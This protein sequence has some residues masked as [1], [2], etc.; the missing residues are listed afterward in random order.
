[1]LRIVVS[2]FSD[3]RSYVA[4]TSP[5]GVV[6][7]AQEQVPFVFVRHCDSVPVFCRSP[8]NPA[9]AAKSTKSPMIK[10]PSGRFLRSGHVAAAVDPEYLTGHE[11]ACLRKQKLDRADDIFRLRQALHRRCRA[12]G[13]KIDDSVL[14]FR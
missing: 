3:D 7:Q 13:F 10:R 9:R 11:I 4:V 2:S 5:E 1:M 12:I 6:Q 14:V 8:C